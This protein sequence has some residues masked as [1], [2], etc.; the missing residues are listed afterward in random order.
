MTTPRLE[1]IIDPLNGHYVDRAPACRGEQIRGP[2]CDT[3]STKFRYQWSS[4]IRAQWTR[5]MPAQAITTWHARYTAL[6]GA[7]IVSYRIAPQIAELLT[8]RVGT[9]R[10]LP[11]AT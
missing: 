6:Q 7:A 1:T 5:Y 3:M 4:S 10:D 9:V 2:A 11:A 8:A